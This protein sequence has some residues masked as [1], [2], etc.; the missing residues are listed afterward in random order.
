MVHLTLNAARLAL[1]CLGDNFKHDRAIPTFGEE[2][3]FPERGFAVAAVEM[4]VVI[5]LWEWIRGLYV[6]IW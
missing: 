5:D 1:C 2:A 6:H 4:I 3:S